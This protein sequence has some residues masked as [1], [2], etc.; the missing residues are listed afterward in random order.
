MSDDKQLVTFKVE[1]ET[2]DI[3]KDK[4]EYG[5]LTDELRPVL[6]RI[7]YGAETTKR[8]QLREKLETLRDDKR[9][10]DDSIRQL[11]KQRKEKS[12]KIERVEDRLDTLRNIEGEYN[13][14]LEMLESQLHQGERIFTKHDGVQRAADVGEKSRSAVIADLKE[15]NPDVPEYAFEL[16]NAHEP[17]NWKELGKHE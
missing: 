16:S 11:Q 2:Y 6:K 10:L 8:E 14:A 15:R 4:L 13:G 7:A 17:V 1:Q 5:Q 12:R 9:G 3:A